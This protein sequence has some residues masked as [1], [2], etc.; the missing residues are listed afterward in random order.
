MFANNSCIYVNWMKSGNENNGW[1]NGKYHE[2]TAE[3][4][5]IES[6][7]AYPGLNMN[8]AGHGSQKRIKDRFHGSITATFSGKGPT[9]DVTITDGNE[10]ATYT[11]T[12]SDDYFFVLDIGD[13]P[14]DNGTKGCTVKI[15][16][17]AIVGTVPD[18]QCVGLV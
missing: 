5:F 10:V 6:R 18:G 14:D 1:N 16:N 2:A 15:K 3:V 13:N 4:D 7:H 8:F 9:V 12:Q 11:I 17:L